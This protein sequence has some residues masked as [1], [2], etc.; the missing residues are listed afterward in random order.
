MLRVEDTKNAA[1][2]ISAVR[3][4]TQLNND[5]AGNVRTE[6]SHKPGN[7]EERTITASL[8]MFFLEES[9]HLSSNRLKFLTLHL[10]GIWWQR[11]F[12]TTLKS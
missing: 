9:N 2:C 6:E 10:E 11:A 4:D 12:L 8:K 7:T 1:F 5:R 3:R